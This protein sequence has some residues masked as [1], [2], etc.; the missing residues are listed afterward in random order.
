M[1]EGA[2]YYFDPQHLQAKLS[3]AGDSVLQ[4][5]PQ[6]LFQNFTETPNAHLQ[7]Q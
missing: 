4:C 5:V 2:K 3:N 7:H 6:I 1:K